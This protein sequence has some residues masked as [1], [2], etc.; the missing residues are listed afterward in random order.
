M[1][2]EEDLRA[3]GDEPADE[4]GAEGGGVA[5]R[6]LGP[7]PLA[8]RDGGEA[9]ADEPA[10]LTTSAGGGVEQLDGELPPIDEAATED[11]Q[12]DVVSVDLDV[13]AVMRRSP[14]PWVVVEVAAMAGAVLARFANTRPIRLLGVRVVLDQP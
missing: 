9:G 13:P 7:A 10:A 4:E 5:G 2:G 1:G 6:H 14:H 3:D 11:D 12:P 8:R